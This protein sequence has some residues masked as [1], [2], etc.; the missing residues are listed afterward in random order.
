MALALPPRLRGNLQA[1]CLVVVE[2][3]NKADVAPPL[4]GVHKGP[5]ELVAE[6]DV[7]RAATPFPVQAR[8]SPLP[9]VAG[10]RVYRSLAARPGHCVSDTGA[11][12]G[13]H[14]RCLTATSV[15]D[16]AEEGLAPHV[17]WRR[18][19]P[20][21]VLELVFALGDGEPH[22]PTDGLKRAGVGSH[23][24]SLLAT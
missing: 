9:V 7:V 15:N 18:T 14:E 21:P 4:G 6:V 24:A 2:V 19:V 22:P 11:G 23:Q 5:G 20:A 8:G 10:A 17:L 3:D 13:V 16:L 12:D 1:S